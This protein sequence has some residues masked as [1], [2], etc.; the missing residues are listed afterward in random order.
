MKTLVNTFFINYKPIVILTFVAFAVFHLLIVILNHYYFRTY[1]YD[2][3]VYN[4][5][6]YN[7]AHLKVSP[8][9]LYLQPYPITFMQDH[10]SL[11]LFFFVPIYWILNWAT[12]T[13]TP[14]IIQW[15]CIVYGA[16]ATYKLI[17][18]KTQNYVVALLALIYYFTL[19]SR[20]SAYGSDCNLAII[21]SAVV[22]VF[23]YYFELKKLIPTL[24]CFSFLIINREDFSLWL[25]FI[26]L[27]LAIVNRKDSTKLKLSALL[28]ILS[29]IS[30]II[31][32]KFI[33]PALEDENKKFDLFNYSAL[34]ATPFEALKFIVLHPINTLKLLYINNSGEAFYDNI[35]ANFYYVYLLS[36]AFILFFRPV[37]LIPF[38]PLIAKKMF[39]DS[40]VRWSLESYYSIEIASI[41]PI[42]I[43]LIL[44]KINRVNLKLIIG[45][46]VVVCTFCT[47]FFL[48]YQN[49]SPIGFGKNNK[50]NL[51]E[52]AFYTSELPINELNKTLN[53][54]PDNA[55]VS[56]SGRISSHLAQ[57]RYI[58]YFPKVSDAE[59]IIL[60]KRKDNWPVSQKQFDEELNKLISTKEWQTLVNNKEFI[61][62]KLI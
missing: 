26:C 25:V 44:I 56:A 12:G 53:L 48:I 35:K 11:S 17:K 14:L 18:F 45:A 21:G 51:F 4:F 3:G 2:Y 38:I 43:F 22:P 37:Y 57:R 46:V 32:F 36:G 30:F 9:P 60:L 16:W 8:C 23:L 61:L 20:Y 49:N 52:K 28:T 31:I 33:I 62:M 58:Y 24:I 13:Y 15:F 7:Y 42:F 54:I 6:L 29:L 55:K 34:G 27:F 59:Y 50:Y 40:P 5:A 1:A 39:N 10:F 19:Y 41:L 47:T